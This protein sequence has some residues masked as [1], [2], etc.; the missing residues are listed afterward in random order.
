MDSWL[1]AAATWV[2]YTFFLSIFFAC[3]IIVGLFKNTHD[4]GKLQEYLKLGTS[5]GDGG[6]LE[7]GQPGT[8][9]TLNEAVPF[10]IKA[11]QKGISVDGVWNARVPS[12]NG[13]ISTEAGSSTTTYGRNAPRIIVSSASVTNLSLAPNPSPPPLQS[14]HRQHVQRPTHHPDPL[15]SHPVNHQSSQYLQVPSRHPHRP[16]RTGTGNRTSVAPSARPF[17]HANVPGTIYSSRRPRYEAH[18]T[19][20]TLQGSGKPYPQPFAGPRAPMLGEIDLTDVRVRKWDGEEE[21]MMKG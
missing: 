1:D 12:T 4:Q 21:E 3:I 10:G 18:R 6:R 16:R 7:D 14:P 15:R 20:A 19:A 11:L 9:E 5:D 8:N 13:H 2:K 17:S